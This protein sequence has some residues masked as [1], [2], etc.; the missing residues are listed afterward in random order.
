MSMTMTEQHHAYIVLMFYRE[1]EKYGSLGVEIFKTA[2][3]MY[4]EERGH[5]M[6]LRAL[7]DGRR[8][9]YAAYFAYGEWESSPGAFQMSMTANKGYVE[10]RVEVCP[11]AGVFEKENCKDCGL[12]YCSQ[13]DKSIVR[14]FNPELELQMPQI[15][16][17][18]GCC[19]FL[20]QDE[21]V[22]ESCFEEGDQMIREAKGPLMLPFC[23][24]C[25][26]VYATFSRVV[27]D[28][29]PKEG[30]SC[31]T[32]I[33]ENLSRLYGSP[34]VECLETYREKNFNGLCL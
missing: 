28:T 4:G 8:L 26:H 7:R 9:D 3:R 31:L 14:G 15:H 22:R 34:F 6:A 17:Q 30:E 27:K 21:S 18:D 1:L 5:R 16:Y 19:H 10:E 32:N 33:R 29:L 24:H 20:F 25:G 12:A 11:W 2:A 23:D 13:I